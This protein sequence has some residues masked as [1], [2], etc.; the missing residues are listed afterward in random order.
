MHINKN[1]CQRTAQ[2]RRILHW[3][4]VSGTAQDFVYLGVNIIGQELSFSFVAV[5][6]QVQSSFFKDKT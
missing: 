3:D 4:L 5:A 6:D 2:N 1:E